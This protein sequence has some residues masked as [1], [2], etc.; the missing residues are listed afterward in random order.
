MSLRTRAAAAEANKSSFV[1]ENSTAHHDALIGKRITRS[2]ARAPQDKSAASQTQGTQAKGLAD[3]RNPLQSIGNRNQAP[4]HRQPVKTHKPSA[5]KPAVAAVRREGMQTRRSLSRMKNAAPAKSEEKA[6]K[7]SH[8]DLTTN[9]SAL[10]FAVPLGIQKPTKPQTLADKLEAKHV[11]PERFDDLPV[12]IE[13]IDIGD[14]DFPEFC[15]DYAKDVYGYLFKREST[16]HIT[17]DYMSEMQTDITPKMRGVLID[18]LIEVHLKFKLLQ[19][20][21]HLTINTIDRYLSVTVIDRN[22]LQLVGVTAMLI[23]S[24]FE[25][26]YAPEVRDF[27]YITDNAYNREEILVMERKILNTLGFKFGVPLCL[28]FLRRM[29][30]SAEADPQTHT[31][32]KY[33]MEMTLTDYHLMQ[34]YKQS[35]IAAASLCLARK[36]MDLDNW[37]ENIVYYSTYDE[38]DITPCVMEIFQIIKNSPRA[39]FQACRKKYSSNRFFRVAHLAEEQAENVL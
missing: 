38:D 20:T 35:E 13:D 1:D 11:L 32:A 26:I 3:R 30:K 15:P 33:F 9:L 12:T 39:K 34:N 8:T 31:L 14:K 21:L 23:A 7:E 24:K 10:G 27:I 4:A 22:R 16:F 29:S 5:K 19:E 17:D 6:P 2:Q 36:M 28:H 18:W 37:N 25:E